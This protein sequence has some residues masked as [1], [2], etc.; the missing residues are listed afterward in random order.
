[1]GL[2]WLA[3]VAL[4]ATLSTTLAVAS[5]DDEIRVIDPY[6]DD[7]EQLCR[8]TVR[9]TRRCDAIDD[10][11]DYAREGESRQHNCD[12]LDE[13]VA[14]CDSRLGDDHV[15]CRIFTA[16]ADDFCEEAVAECGVLAVDEELDVNERITSC[17]ERFTFVMQG[18]G[19]LVLYQ[20]ATALWNS[21]TQGNAG[22]TAIMQGDGN[23]VVYAK[24]GTALWNSGT[25]GNAGATLAVQDDGN[26]VI[27]STDGR[28]LWS[29]G[30]CCH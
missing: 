9:S 19:N 15:A 12:D 6:L 26:V 7:L 27:Y 16:L 10:I 22:A 2:R 29:T 24:N 17:D 3:P 25:Q 4:V 20:G 13:L 21:M 8:D 14:R 30:T 18:D 1:M 23:L 28:A 11:G 5:T